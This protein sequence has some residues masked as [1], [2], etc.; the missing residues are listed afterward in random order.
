[1]KSINPRVAESVRIMLADGRRITSGTVAA[2]AAVSVPTAYHALLGMVENGTLEHVGAGRGAHFCP[3]Q[4]ALIEVRDEREGLE[5]DAVWQRLATRPAIRALK[6]NVRDILH[7]GVTEMVNNA[8]DH[9]RGEGVVTRVF[10]SGQAIGFEVID[11]GIGIFNSVKDKFG[12]KTSFEA[13]AELQ[14]GKVTTAPEAHTGLGIF[15]TSKMGDRMTLESGTTRWVIDSI[16]QDQAVEEAP[17][18]E[19]TLV[20]FEIDR[21]SARQSKDVYDRFSSVE[22]GVTRSRTSVKLFR[23]EGGRIVSRSEG[24]RLVAGL[25][26]FE[27]VEL[28]FRDVQGIGQG[29]ADEVFRVWQREHPNTRLIPVNA[30][31]AVMFL[32]RAARAEPSGSTPSQTSAS[33][34]LGTT[35]ATLAP[36][37]TV[38]VA[39]TGERTEEP[40]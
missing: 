38:T 13:I 34:S 21:A 2:H 35:T 7:I 22:Q 26:K 40:V 33:P 23:G 31:D 19:G 5:E 1:M 30:N 9:S 37:N 36:S 8:I 14:K 29:F 20:R 6:P 10:R 39:S 28:D 25:E 4:P 27:E 24:K 17:P 3:V 18:R 32:I 15:F 16:R 11:D 12:L